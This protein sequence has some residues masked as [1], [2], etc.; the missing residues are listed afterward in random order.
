MARRPGR[1]PLFDGL[2]AI[3]ALSV[4][5][6]HFAAYTSSLNTGALRAVTSQLAAGVCVFFLISGFLLYRPFVAARLERGSR[7]LPSYARGR[8]LRIVPAYWFALTVLALWPGLPG[9]FTRDA[10]VY[11]LFGQN[12]SVHTFGHG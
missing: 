3:A 8:V 12:Y 9:V 5:A 6:V 7:D 1:F 11:Y 10:W 4:V 2:R